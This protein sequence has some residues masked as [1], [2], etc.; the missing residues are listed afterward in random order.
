MTGRRIEPLAIP[1]PAG[2]LQAQ[3]NHPVT[4]RPG[5]A[6]LCHP[7][8]LHGGT[9]HTKA[10]YH[11]ARALTHC[12]LPV[13]RFNFRGV[14]ASRGE[15]TGGPGEHDDARAALATVIRRHPGEPLIVGGFSFGAWVGCA[16]GQEVPEVRGLLALGPPLDLYDFGFVRGDR[17]ILC[18]AGDRDE[19]V[20]EQALRDWAASLGENARTVIL[21]GAQHLL[22]T[23]LTELESAVGAFARDLLG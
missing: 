6:L 7:H 21:P 11:A 13:L 4:P 22:T 1:G 16:I 19:F 18:L 23:H 2:P 14:G 3:W 10:V 17:A 20:R 12:G 9:M 5:A 15:H 8:P